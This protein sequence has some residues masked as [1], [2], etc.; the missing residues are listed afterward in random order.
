MGTNHHKVDLTDL[1]GKKVRKLTVLR[2]SH[3]E[4]A[5]HADR[6]RNK[7]MYLCQCDCGKET[8]V[9]RFHLKQ[10]DS[11]SATWSC[12]CYQKQQ[13]LVGFEKQKGKARPQIQKPNGESI[14]NTVFAYYKKGATKRQLGFQLSKEEFEALTKQNC[15][16]CDTAPR[17]MT[18]DSGHVTRYM[19]GVDRLNS[20]L[21]YTIENCV[22][23]CKT[24]NY[25]KL[26]SS[27]EDF[28]KQ[29]QK[30]ASKHPSKKKEIY[31]L[32]GAPA[33]GKSWVLKSILSTFSPVDSDDFSRSKLIEE[34]NKCDKIPI[35]ALTIGISTFIKNNP[36]FDV[37][38]LVIQEELSVLRMRMLSRGGTVT[39]TLEKRAKRM[40]QLALKAVFA[41]TSEDVLEYLK[42]TVTY[43]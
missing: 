19:N 23:C 2:F 17:L 22:P 29:V 20:D 28:L 39:S 6:I 5:E 33:S 36:Q 25:M 40:S 37:K 27:V 13:S 7:Y 14:F 34:I 30:I 9:N 38:L 18:K 1:V 35:V 16:Y 10:K 24:C 21:D 32:T 31:L 4:K 43:G 26:D 12:G 41:G 42:K 3:I 11:A 15:H 8:L